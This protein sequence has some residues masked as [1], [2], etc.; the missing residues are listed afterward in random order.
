MRVLCGQPDL[1]DNFGGYS[2]LVGRG[3]DKIVEEHPRGLH[4]SNDTMEFLAEKGLRRHGEMGST[5]TQWSGGQ[6][7]QIGKT[8]E[9]NYLLFASNE[10]RLEIGLTHSYLER[11]QFGFGEGPMGNWIGGPAQGQKYGCLA[12]G[13]LVC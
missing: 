3:F 1:G 9:A 8:M 6:A 13:S 11:R 5:R 4:E 2:F 12:I 10:R 7:V